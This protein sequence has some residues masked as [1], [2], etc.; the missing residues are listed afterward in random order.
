M[1][2]LHGDTT[3]VMPE[4]LQ[5]DINFNRLHIVAGD[6]VDYVPQTQDCILALNTTVHTLERLQHC[7]DRVLCVF[8]SNEQWSTM[9]HALDQGWTCFMYVDPTRRWSYILNLLV[10]SWMSGQWRPCA[11][12]SEPHFSQ[13]RTSFLRH[14]IGGADFLTVYPVDMGSTTIPS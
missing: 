13:W 14:L 8:E 12:L 9:V 6:A 3:L 1:A 5:T 7:R 4:R 10:G 11:Q 2:R